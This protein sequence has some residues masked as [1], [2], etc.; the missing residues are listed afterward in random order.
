MPFDDTGMKASAELSGMLKDEGLYL[1]GPAA[2]IAH[3]RYLTELSGKRWCARVIRAWSAKEEE[4]DDSDDSDAPRGPSTHSHARLGALPPAPKEEGHPPSTRDEDSVIW[5]RVPVF[6]DHSDREWIQ[7]SRFSGYEM[8]DV[9]WDS[10]EEGICPCCGESH[11]GSSFL[12][13]LLDE[14]LAD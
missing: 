13:F 11:P 2:F 10:D 5:K 1:D 9:D 3:I 7:F 4:D 6:R 12:E 14:D 8:T